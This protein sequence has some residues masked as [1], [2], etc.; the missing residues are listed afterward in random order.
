MKEVKK[1]IADSFNN[2]FVNVGPSLSKILP[3]DWGHFL[4]K[5]V[6]HHTVKAVFEVLLGPFMGCKVQG[7]NSRG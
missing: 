1:Q 3:G 4:V 5:N 6:E 7:L 2:Y